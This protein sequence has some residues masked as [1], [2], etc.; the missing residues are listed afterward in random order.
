MMQ[1]FLTHCLALPSALPT[2]FFVRFIVHSSLP[3]TCCQLSMHCA[4][5]VA[6]AETFWTGYRSRTGQTSSI[7]SLST[8]K[9]HFRH[10][11]HLPLF[12][13]FPIFDTPYMPSPLQFSC[14]ASRF[15]EPPT[16]SR[17]VLPGTLTRQ[18]LL[19]LPCTPSSIFDLSSLPL[20]SHLIYIS[21][22]A[23]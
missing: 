7:K 8:A 4:S 2:N 3:C 14:N 13:S 23:E 12:S 19:Y 11:P 5:S 16:M 15:H 20:L 18:P 1:P 9:T 17:R 21:T 6:S 22:I 10:L